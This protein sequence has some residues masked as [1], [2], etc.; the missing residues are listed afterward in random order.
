LIQLHGNNGDEVQTW[1]VLGEVV[2]VHIDR[3]LLVDGIYDTAAA[4]PILRAGNSATTPK[5][6]PHPCS[7]CCGPPKP[8]EH[9]SR[10]GQA[11]STMVHHRPTDRRLLILG[12]AG[13]IAGAL[14]G[15]HADV[16]Y[17]GV[18]Q[19]GSGPSEVSAYECRLDVHARSVV[20]CCLDREAGEV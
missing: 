15:R 3:E 18:G 1:L 14:A 12:S 8:N 5:L 4:H 10:T 6:N 19:L 16:V 13:F 9:D 7:Q 11:W 20:G 2:A 17:L